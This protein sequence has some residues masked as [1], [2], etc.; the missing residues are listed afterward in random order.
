MSS[1]ILDDNSISCY[2]YDS[3]N[4]K[5]SI[6]YSKTGLGTNLIPVPVYERD[7]SDDFSSS[8]VSY[9]Y[10][11]SNYASGGSVC[12]DSQFF[13]L[14]LCDLCCSGTIPDISYD[15]H[16]CCVDSQTSVINESALN[17]LFCND[18]F[19]VKSIPKCDAKSYKE[20]KQVNDYCD[21]YCTER[22]SYVLPGTTNAKSGR[23]FSLAKQNYSA[24]GTSGS[25]DGPILS[26][27]KRC[28]MVVNT[29]KWY[30]DYNTVLNSEINS[31]NSNQSYNALKKIWEEAKS[32]ATKM[33]LTYHVSC[34]KTIRHDPSFDC[35][36]ADCENRKPGNECINKCSCPDT[37]DDKSG[38]ITLNNVVDKY[39]INFKLY[40]VLAPNIGKDYLYI[41]Y[42]SNLDAKK[43]FALSEF[44]VS[45]LSGLASKAKNDYYNNLSDKTDVSCSDG[46]LTTDIGGGEINID[47]KINSASSSIS[48]T[49]SNLKSSV[50]AATTLEQELTSCQTYFSSSASSDAAMKEIYNTDPNLDFSYSQVYFDS[51]NKTRT[52][53]T[54]EDFTKNCIRHLGLGGSSGINDADNYVFGRSGSGGYAN[55]TGIDADTYHESITQIHTRDFSNS[56]INVLDPITSY[57]SHLSEPYAEKYAITNDAL[58]S[59]FCTWSIQEKELYTNIPYGNVE[60]VYLSGEVSNYTQHNNYLF[61]YKTTLSGTYLTKFTLSNIGTNGKFD[62]YI[63]QGTMCDNNQGNASCELKV[64][65]TIIDTGVCNTQGA[66]CSCTGTDCST[67]KHPTLTYEFKIVDPRNLFPTGKKYNGKEIAKNWSDENINT[68]QNIGNQDKTYSPDNLT[69]SFKLTASDIRSIKEYNSSRVSYGGFDDFNLQCECGSTCVK[70]KS[71]FL[72]AITGGESVNGLSLNT[73][74]RNDESLDTLRNT[75]TW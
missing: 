36:N 63:Y 40:N 56:D 54:Q 57:S 42:S 35:C 69:Y 1:S 74:N 2:Y 9:V 24:F 46:S 29:D 72:N 17:E 23:Y 28:R 16:N 68:V 3:S 38:D 39:I 31:Y 45:S 59:I 73:W 66:V 61:V 34:S 70:C 44:Y 52:D 13:N 58:Y 7:D 50:T 20:K 33:S 49:N 53:E 21:I 15:V 32:G 60:I 12:D 27:T 25:V 10:V 19:G 47:D 4:N 14:S 22:A 71:K 64:E 18:A 67:F 37:Y 5:V 43:T 51:S 62:Q 26:G 11:S 75:L 30:A 6:S 41:K 65:N 48:S 55:G 8:P